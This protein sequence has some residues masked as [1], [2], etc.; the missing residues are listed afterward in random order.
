MQKTRRRLRDKVLIIFALVE[1]D[2]LLAIAEE[3]EDRR[4]D[5]AK[6]GMEDEL[7]VLTEKY[8]KILAD[9]S[10]DE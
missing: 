10:A 6:A 3:G 7:R 4:L 2:L 9:I 5:E 8:E 1:Y